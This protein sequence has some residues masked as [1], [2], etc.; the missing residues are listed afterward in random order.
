MNH[1]FAFAKWVPSQA[2]AGLREKLGAIHGKRG[3]ANHGIRLDDAVRK[4]IIGGAIVRFVPAVG[5]FEPE[6]DPQ[7][8]ILPEL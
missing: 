1:G 6:A 3:M 7:I 8:K 4:D 5:R 2:H